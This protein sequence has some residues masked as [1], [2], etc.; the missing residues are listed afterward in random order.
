M[1][2][3]DN[4]FLLDGVLTKLIAKKDTVLKLVKVDEDE[5]EDITLKITENDNFAQS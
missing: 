4:K 2:I 3:F 1:I 5:D